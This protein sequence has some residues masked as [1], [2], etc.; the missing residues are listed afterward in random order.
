MIWYLIAGL[1][2]LL[3]LALLILNYLRERRYLKKKTSQAMSPELW[4][5]IEVEREASRERQRLFHE[6]MEEAK[7]VKGQSWKLKGFFP[8]SLTYL[9][10]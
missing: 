3:A 2:I 10:S 1:L 9:T 4:E 6:A 7:K 5:E 8:L